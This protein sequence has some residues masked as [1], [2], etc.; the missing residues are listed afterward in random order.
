LRSPGLSARCGKNGRW[1]AS[2]FAS[3]RC[4]LCALGSNMGSVRRVGTA[5]TS[6]GSANGIQAHA[7]ILVH[8]RPL[9]QAGWA[10]TQIHCAPTSTVVQP[11][12]CQFCCQTS[13]PHGIPTLMEK[14]SSRFAEARVAMKSAGSCNPPVSS[15]RKVNRPTSLRHRG[16]LRAAR[17]G[18]S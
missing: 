9:C 8:C 1:R 13:L 12:C 5:S 14:A 4:C 7:F 2:L 3:V 11:D 17:T 16:G 6:L 15:V 10:F 18:V